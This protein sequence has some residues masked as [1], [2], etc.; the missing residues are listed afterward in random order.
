[1]HSSLHSRRLSAFRDREKH[2][3]IVGEQESADSRM[4]KRGLANKLVLL[5]A[6]RI[7]VVYVN[8]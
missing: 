8:Q 3:S 1:M 6:L 7:L 5:Q 4:R 2:D